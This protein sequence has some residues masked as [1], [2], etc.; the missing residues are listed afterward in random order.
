MTHFVVT[1]LPEIEITQ[2]VE[3]CIPEGCYR[4]ITP[5]IATKI[6]CERYKAPKNV[7][8]GSLMN[9]LFVDAFA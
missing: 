4:T 3:V 8:G 1:F 2:D 5:S 6:R 7:S 9:A